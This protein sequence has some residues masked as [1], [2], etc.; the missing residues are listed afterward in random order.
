MKQKVLFRTPAPVL[1]PTLVHDGPTLV[2]VIPGLRLVSEANA[3]EHWRARAA[4]TKTQKLTVGL[5]LH[6]LVAAPPS[7]P[8][9]IVIVRT[10]PG[11]LDDDNLQGSGKHV[12]D[13]V[14]KWIGIDDGRRAGFRCRVEQTSAGRG[15]YSVTI[16][17]GPMASRETQLCAEWA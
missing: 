9:D 12:R 10:S 1:R 6:S 15:V 4:R 17:I 11:T 7:P 16:R 8:V 14:A 5:V 3:R 2:V 13:A